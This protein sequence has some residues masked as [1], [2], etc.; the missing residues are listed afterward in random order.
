MITIIIVC[1]MCAAW[2]LFSRR[3]R[4]DDPALL[5]AGVWLSASGAYLAFAE[6]LMIP[7]DYALLVVSCGIVSFSFGVWL[8]DRAPTFAL[9]RVERNPLWLHACLLGL[10]ACAFAAMLDRALTLVPGPL[11][12]Q[13]L[14]ALR[15]AVT[16][17]GQ[18][19]GVSAYLANL[20]FA[21]AAFALLTARGAYQSL[22]ATLTILLAICCGLLL[23]GRTFLLLLATLLFSAFIVR[24]GSTRARLVAVCVVV[25]ATAAVFVS[26]TVFQGRSA[27]AAN[28]WTSALRSEVLHYVPAGLA[29]FN[30]EVQKDEPLTWGLR[31]F[32]SFF[33]V[34]ERAG[35]DVTVVPLVRPYVEVPFSTNVYTAMSPYFSDF[36]I[37]GVIAAFLAFGTVTAMTYRQA[38]LDQHPMSMMLYGI[39][40]YALLLQPFQDQYMSLA[41]QWVQLLLA[42]IVFSIATRIQ[43][44]S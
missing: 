5:H 17:G 6:N 38:R 1:L 25:G 27:I 37:I 21:A 44:R 3:L 15:K 12:S 43:T 7:D 29:A 36:G 8:G 40:L 24:F 41:S 9:P 35:A 23:T 31:T 28:D 19:F 13:W 18:S 16:A 4:L 2:H 14:G 11:D 26:V 20:A 42:A 33:A 39:M 22:S 32:R 34:L 10:S 30:V